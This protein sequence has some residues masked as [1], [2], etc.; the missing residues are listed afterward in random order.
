ME[1][2][3]WLLAPIW[4]HLPALFAATGCL[5]V[6]AVLVR[7][8]LGIPCRRAIGFASVDVGL[9][10]TLGAILLLTLVQHGADRRSLIL[11]PFVE[12]HPNTVPGAAA[13]IVGNV[14][15]FVPI[16]LLAPI[17]WPSLDSPGRI[18]L[19]SATLSIA[20]ELIQW[21]AAT[22][23]QSSVTDVISNATGAALGYLTLRT[24]RSLRRLPG[25]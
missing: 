9:V 7:V 24:V 12:F 3:W 23:R 11:V 18:L 14:M 2:F 16:G 25:A 19:A 21:I 8:A 20:I 17:R 4:E 5:W 1:E 6:I 15:M 22:G 10:T 13:Q